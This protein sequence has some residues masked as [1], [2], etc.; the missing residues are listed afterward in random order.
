MPENTQE[1]PVN[2]NKDN[3][4]RNFLL[5]SF[6]LIVTSLLFIGFLAGYYF[7]NFSKTAQIGAGQI[8]GEMISGLKNPYDQDYFTLLVLGL[9]KRED[10]K[11]LLT[12]TILLVTIDAGS[13]NYILFSIPRDLWLD[14]LKTKINALYYYGKEKDPNDGSQ[15]VEDKIEEILDW[16][17]D[18]TMVLEMNDIKK[19]VDSVGGVEVDIERAFID[20]NYPKDNGSNEIIT[21]EFEEGE[22]AL[23]GERA[24]QFMRSRK[25]ENEVEGS[26]EARQKRQKKIILAIKGKLLKSAG[27]ILNP[28][29]LGSL[30]HFL[31]T[32]IEVK[33]EM[34]IKDI[35]SL[36]KLANKLRVGKQKEIEIPWKE[37]KGQLLISGRDPIHY[38]WILR[39]KDKTWGEIRKLFKEAVQDFPK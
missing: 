9:D 31:A 7:L 32:E 25:S 29:K 35:F 19:L 27:I 38:T 33:P 6:S 2:T 28:Q 4:L 23:D 5:L 3:Y 30:Y 11:T 26:D 36:W 21:V 16:R 13:G 14:D 20:E 10:Q 15:M 24:L 22:Q 1:A 34:G 37:G 39:P 17:I 18:K 12:D 8:A